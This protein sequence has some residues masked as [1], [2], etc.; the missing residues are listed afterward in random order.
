MKRTPL[1]VTLLIA[2]TLTTASSTFAAE[3][4]SDWSKAN[5]RTW[6]GKQYW[7]NRLHDWQIKDGRL[8]CVESRA[9]HPMRTVHLVTHTMGAKTIAFEMSVHTGTIGPAES[10]SPR[11]A[12]GFLFGIQAGA[13][14]PDPRAAAIVHANPGPGA[15]YFAGMTA[16]GRLVIFDHQQ[17]QAMTKAL[18]AAAADK[19]D[20]AGRPTKDVRLKLSA[21]SPQYGVTEITLSAHDPETDKVL[22]HVKNTIHM[23]RLPGNVALVS[24]PGAAS[25]GKQTGRFWFKDWKVKGDNLV[26]TDP[27]GVGPVMCTQHTLDN[28]G[29]IDGHVMK[30]TAQFMPV[31]ERDPQAAQ[32]Q[33]QRG[34]DWKQVADAKLIVPGWTAT[35]RI[36][37]WDATRDTPY[38]VVY[39][40]KPV[41]HGTVRRDPVK[42]DAI[43]VAGFTGNHMSWYGIG[44]NKRFDWR[45]D[46]WFP[47][48]DLTSKV[49][50]QKP[51]V[52]FFSGDQVYEGASPTYPD[53]ANIKLDYL[54]KWYL[55]CWAYRDLTKDIPTI[56]IPDDHDVY[57]GNIWGEGGRKSPGRDHHG[58]YVYPADFVKMVERTQCAHLPDP[59]DPTPVGQ[60]IG[61]YYSDMVYGRV[62]FA[63]IEDRKFKSGCARPE[64][65]PTGTPRPD[66]VRSEAFDMAT[67]DKP[68]LKLLGDRQ[69]KFL[70]H[71]AQDWR[72]HD[73]KMV[74]SQ[75]HFANMATHHGGGLQYLRADLDS[76]GWPQTGRNKAV[77]AMRR[78]FMFHLAGDQH[79]ATL[80]QHGI[81]EHGDGNWAMTVPSVANFY[82]RAWSPKNKGKYVFPD[83]KDF[84]GDHVD[85]LVNKVTVYAASNPGTPGTTSGHKPAKLHD[86]MPG[87]GIVKAVKSKR[88]YV[89]ECWP[90][91]AVPGQHKQYPGWPRTISQQS[92][93]GRKAVAWLPTI[94]VKGKS[95]PVVQVIAESNGEVVYTLRIEG[96]TFRPKVYAKGKYT[97]RVGDP[98]ADTWQVVKGI[99]SVDKS[100]QRAIDVSF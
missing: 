63:I 37:R 3:V 84:A 66:H 74:L 29:K 4:A 53:R 80:I 96:D 23:R 92:N 46:M 49:A 81:H 14:T 54:Y 70:R 18:S 87:Y 95:S 59:F 93:D 57:Q 31:G 89:A 45:N 88:A 21:V 10:V 82:P 12:T 77:D 99:E 13:G 38:R 55:W 6:V 11:A 32:L 73:M 39:G 75:T 78:G 97:V 43:S 52:L 62:G 36:P 40:G 27:R 76:N 42:K 28:A 72:G 83:E 34:G 41:W 98:D 58:G 60:G 9:N 100:S 64:M 17:P 2:V 8:E 7:A 90:R 33:V 94:K 51:D 35:F 85:G 26:E 44:S 15:G 69:L 25:K 68:G 50:M 19:R 61:V 20:N 56:C 48:A 91:Y 24:H 71:F 86:R 79:L 65:P 16:A 67:L 5:D 22:G 47:H 30:M 1:I